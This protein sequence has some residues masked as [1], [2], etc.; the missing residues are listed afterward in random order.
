MHLNPSGLDV[1]TMA[2]ADIVLGL[3]KFIIHAYSVI[4]LPFYFLYYRC[5]KPR[6]AFEVT[7]ARIVSHGSNEITYKAVP[8]HNR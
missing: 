7:K 4:T 8:Y 6:D 2:A 1:G 3:V 5:F